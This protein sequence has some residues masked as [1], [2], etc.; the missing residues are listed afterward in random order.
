M[1]SAAR[2]RPPATAAGVVGGLTA[3]VALANPFRHHLTPPCL[4]HA[5]TG[6]WCPLCGGTRAVW[7][8]AHG[9]FALMLHANALL[10]AIVAGAAWTWL[11][12]VGRATG[13]WRLPVPKGRSFNVVLIV[14]LVAFA[15]L[16]NLPGLSA[17]APPP[18]P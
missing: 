17:L 2:L 3:F 14:V 18:S 7:A 5:T 8:A 16:R 10:P 11:G 6:L 12:S 13:W 1:A 9:D 4:L 15:V